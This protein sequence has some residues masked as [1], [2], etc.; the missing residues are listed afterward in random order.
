[1][2]QWLRGCVSKKRYSSM[3]MADQV[4]KKASRRAGR[5]LRV[6]ECMQCQGYHLTKQMNGKSL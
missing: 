6:Y 1:M 2:R 3:S 5:E 4:R